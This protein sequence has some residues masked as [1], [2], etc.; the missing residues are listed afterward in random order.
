MQSVHSVLDIFCGAGGLSKGLHMGLN[1]DG[2]MAYRVVGAIDNW[3]A[4]CETFKINHGIEPV[5][6]KVT[7]E[8]V[9]KALGGRK[10]VDIVCGGPPCQGFTTMRHGGKKN[11]D[12]ITRVLDD[13]RNRCVLAFVEAVEQVKPLAFLMENVSGFMT[14]QK[15][16][17]HR[18]VVERLRQGY[19]I[20][21]KI[22]LAADHGVPQMRRRFILIGT[23]D[24]EFVFPVRSVAQD[25]TFRE[26]TDD[27]P[28]I[29]GRYGDVLPYAS[30][31]PRN[32]YQ[33]AMRDGS[34]PRSCTEHTAS[35]HSEKIL[36]VISK[37]KEGESATD[38]KVQTR[39]LAEGVDLKHMVRTDY[40]GN[41]YARIFWDRPAPTITRN[42][43]TPSSSNCVHPS[44]PRGLTVREG[45]RCQ[46]FPDTYRFAGT[47]GDK[48][49]LIGNAVP[50]LLGLALG[51][52]LLEHL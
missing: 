26:A 44:Q 9:A 1:S 31:D 48:R 6:D 34:D 4:A 37:L 40:F 50:P 3:P 47:H 38:P 14:F 35:V 7:R 22:V 28:E 30:V 52:A 25:R 45:A 15:G 8:S 24:R 13:E 41:T 5:C 16:Q 27:L 46:S 23:T 51:R 2:A 43:T 10:T 11:L 21:E 18:E 29:A 33:Q 20:A 17:L 32:D 42:F 39:L 19:K 49:L 12:P 36:A